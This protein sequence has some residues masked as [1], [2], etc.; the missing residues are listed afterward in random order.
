MSYGPFGLEG[1]R[2]LI[3]GASSGIG[4]S[5]AIEISKAGAAECVLVGRSKERLEETASLLES[6]C[7]AT[8][9]VCDLSVTEELCSLVERLP[10]LD[11]A[12]LNAGIN[13]MRPVSFIKGTDIT[14]I[15]SVNCFAP[16][17]LTK[18]IIKK[19]KLK[20]PSSVVF[21]A[22]IAG[23][24]NIVMGNSIYGASKCALSAFMK[25]C[26]IEY[27]AKGIRFNAIHPGIIETPLIHKDVSEEDLTRDQKRYPLKR[28]GRPEEV[29]YAMVYLLS[30]AS[31]WVTG[32]DL[33]IDGG[34]SLV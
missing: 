15:F 19:K 20:N 28:Y 31:A 10:Q 34:R 2:I 6:G 11:G 21:T 3:T 7:K 24:S 18:Q 25:Y 23:Y 14:D 4:R 17:L 13:K 9:E 22:S 33:V 16:M 27:S 8:V 30:D 5:A 26:A 1:K 32:S 29:A 12:I